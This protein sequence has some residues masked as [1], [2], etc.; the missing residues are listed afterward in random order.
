M[1]LQSLQAQ[2]DADVMHASVVTAPSHK[3]Q[4]AASAEHM[5]RSHATPA[6]NPVNLSD[7]LSSES[8]IRFSS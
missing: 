8:H 2:S 3:R 6:V 7:V 4:H 5:N 1:G